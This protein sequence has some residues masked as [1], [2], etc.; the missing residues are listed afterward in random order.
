[1]PSKLTQQAILG[2]MIIDLAQ[3]DAAKLGRRQETTARQSLCFHTKL[4][5]RTERSPG[6]SGTNKRCCVRYDVGVV[7]NLLAWHVF[8]SFLHF[9]LSMKK[10]FQGN[11]R[12]QV[13]TQ[14]S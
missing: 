5:P 1:M 10:V 11:C 3:T 8:G 4:A 9:D 2:S 6:N 14:T 7:G 12:I 13:N